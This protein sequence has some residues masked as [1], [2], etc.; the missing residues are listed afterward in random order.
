MKEVCFK[1]SRKS[2]F[3]RS[4]FAISY[5]YF[6]NRLYEA[7]LLSEKISKKK[8]NIP[9]L[10]PCQANLSE[11]NNPKLFTHCNNLKFPLPFI[12]IDDQV[13]LISLRGYNGTF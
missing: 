7:L 6:T 8:Q 1:T 5:Y 11:S 13:R 10:T 2:L 4:T 12:T 9:G 3:T